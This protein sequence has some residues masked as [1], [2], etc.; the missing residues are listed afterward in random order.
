MDDISVD[1]EEI[2][3][4]KLNPDYIQKLLDKIND[5]EAGDESV[6]R[7]ELIMLNAEL[8]AILMKLGSQ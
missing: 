4:E 6:N 2:T 3:D 7:T 8:D 5:L 1:P